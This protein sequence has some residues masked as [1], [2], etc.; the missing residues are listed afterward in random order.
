M[1]IESSHLILWCLL[2]LPSVFSSIRDFSNES[3]VRIQKPKYWSFSFSIRPSNEYSGLIS[4]KIDWFYLLAAQ[5]ALRSLLQHHKPK[6]SIL[7]CSAF[8]T[9]QLSQLYV[10]TGKTMPWLCRLLSPEQ[11]LCFSTHCLGLSY[12]KLSFLPRSSHLRFQG[13]SQHLQWFWSRR[14][15]NLSRLPH[16]SPLIF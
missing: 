10:T 3:A 7:W 6:A 5:G 12:D 16:L 8:F 2:L 15:G 1:S 14:R 11:C 13:C 9:V 4:L